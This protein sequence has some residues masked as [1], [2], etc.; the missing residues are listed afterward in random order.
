MALSGCLG[1]LSELGSILE[2]NESKSNTSSNQ[3]SNNVSPD[4]AGLENVSLTVTNAWLPEVSSDGVEV[5]ILFELTNPT[6]VH[7][8][9]NTISYTLSV[10]GLEFASGSISRCSI[11]NY[12]PDGNITEE[13]ALEHCGEE[14]LLKPN[15]TREFR[16]SR[17]T[18]KIQRI[19]EL[20]RELRQ[21][22]ELEVETRVTIS[23]WDSSYQTTGSSRRPLSS[24]RL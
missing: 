18:P 3:T 21:A 12:E 23:V 4:P 15:T 22:N 14:N 6:D 10:P 24:A 11:L 17:H 20:A 16:I 1:D 8:P 5:T 19:D 7:V 2:V 9:I 13:E